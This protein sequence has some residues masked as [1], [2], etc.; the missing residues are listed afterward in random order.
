[1]ILVVFVELVGAIIVA[2]ILGILYEGLKTL[3]EWLIYRDI[4]QSNK[5]KSDG[6]YEN[7]NETDISSLVGK[8]K[9]RR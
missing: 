9:N 6:E 2:Y 7:I 5:I 3:R 1:M 8:N 4:K